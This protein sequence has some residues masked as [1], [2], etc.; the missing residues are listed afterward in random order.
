MIKCECNMDGEWIGM[1]F[2]IFLEGCVVT[3]DW[4]SAVNVL[5]YKGQGESNVCRIYRAGITGAFGVPGEN[6]NG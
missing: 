5:L 1:L 3:A 2:N 6:D 4:R